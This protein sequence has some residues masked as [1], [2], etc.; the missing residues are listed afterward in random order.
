MKLFAEAQSLNMRI[1]LLTV[2]DK[3]NTLFGVG[4]NTLTAE[5]VKKIGA[6]AERFHR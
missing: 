2:R 1:R 4:L 5:L 3:D 6:T